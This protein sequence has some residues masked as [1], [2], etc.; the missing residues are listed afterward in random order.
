LVA[1]F[2][3]WARREN[4]DLVP[5][6]CLSVCPRP[7]GLA[8]RAEGKFTYVF[9]D[10]TPDEDEAAIIECATLYRRTKTGF[11]PRE[12]RPRA[13]QASILARVPPLNSST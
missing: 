7:C 13:L 6:E 2:A 3:S 10:L 1:R 8:L 5:Y 11:L 9:G 12:E 4:F